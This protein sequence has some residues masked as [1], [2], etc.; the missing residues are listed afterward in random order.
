MPSH[1]PS[2]AY[3]KVELFMG[4][5]LTVPVTRNCFRPPIASLTSFGIWTTAPPPPA[6]C[7]T[8]LNRYGLAE[9]CGS[10]INA[11]D[12]GTERDDLG[13]DLLISAVDVL[14]AGDHRRLIRRQRRQDERRAR[15]QVSDHHLAP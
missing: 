13:L 12:L 9:A 2:P 1:S 10:A 5:P 3:G 11:M 6:F 7:S 4:T 14:H 15:A 8:D